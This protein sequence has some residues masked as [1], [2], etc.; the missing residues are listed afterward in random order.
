MLFVFCFCMWAE[1]QV[2]SRTLVQP[3]ACGRCRSVRACMCEG[4]LRVCTSG[5]SSRM[6]NRQEGVCSPA[7]LGGVRVFRNQGSAVCSTW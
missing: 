7:R 1:A 2:C 3:G 4:R 5:R 6:C